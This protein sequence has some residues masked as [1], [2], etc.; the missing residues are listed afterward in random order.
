MQRRHY[1]GLQC[2]PYLVNIMAVVVLHDRFYNKFPCYLDV[3]QS[4]DSCAPH[5]LHELHR[6]R[7]V[8]QVFRLAEHVCAVLLQDEI[9]EDGG[10]ENLVG[11]G[12]REELAEVRFDVRTV[13]LKVADPL[14]QLLETLGHGEGREHVTEAHREEARDKLLL[15]WTTVHCERNRP[16]HDYIAVERRVQFFDATRVK[17][18]SEPYYKISITLSDTKYSRSAAST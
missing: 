5:V 16:H 7:H 15:L 10:R 8:E 4:S 1:M 9:V 17:C 14:E 11:D 18:E 6:V 2:N 12:S 3:L 13:E